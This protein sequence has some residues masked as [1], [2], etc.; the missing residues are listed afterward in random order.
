MIMANQTQLLLFW[1]LSNAVLASVILSGGGSSEAFSEGGNGNRTA[2]YMLVI[3]SE[4]CPTAMIVYNLMI[5]IRRWH[6]FVQVYL[7]YIVSHNAPVWCLNQVF[8]MHNA[9]SNLLSRV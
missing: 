8:D 6:G 3:L 4:F 9:T 7:F 2:V 5:S 1:S